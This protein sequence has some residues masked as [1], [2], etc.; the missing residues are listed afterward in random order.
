MG[1]LLRTCSKRGAVEEKRSQEETTS[2]AELKILPRETL[3][4][5]DTNSIESKTPLILLPDNGRQW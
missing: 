3:E 5:L 4:A 2:I 1:K